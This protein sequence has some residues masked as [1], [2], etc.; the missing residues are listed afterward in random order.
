MGPGGSTWG[1]MAS[2]SGLNVGSGGGTNELQRSQ[3]QSGYLMVCLTLPHDSICRLTC[4]LVKYAE[5]SGFLAL[6]P[7]SILMNHVS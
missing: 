7:L 4:L 1:S 3:Y 2:S 5:R 6:H